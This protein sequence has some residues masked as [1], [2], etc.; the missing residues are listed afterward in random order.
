MNP[1][2][3]QEINLLREL[4]GRQ[5]DLGIVIGSHQNLDTY[6]AG[7]SLYA[8]LKAAG[9]K[10]Q[11]ISK[12][13]PT[14]EV[15]NLVGIDKVRENFVSGNNSKLVISLPYIKGEVEKVL[16]T[17]FPNPQNPTNINFHLTA[18]EG[19]SITPFSL[20]DVKLI[21]EGG[22]PGAIIT[23][24]V[25]YIDELAGIADDPQIKI[26]NI[27]NFSG[28]SRFGDVVLVD[29]SFSSLSEVS[30]KI[31]KDLALPVDID[32]AQNVLDGVLFATRNFTKPNTSPLAFEAASTAMYN[33]AQRSDEKADTRVQEQRQNPRPQRFQER[34]DDQREASQ[35]KPRVS[36][37]D[38]PAMH[39]QGSRNQGDER[40]QRNQQRGQEERSR[41]PQNQSQTRQFQDR[42]QR[43]QQAFGQNPQDIEELMRRINEENA[44]RNI[45]KRQDQPR[46]ERNQSQNRSEDRRESFSNPRVQDAEVVE[47]QAQ[48]R[49][50]E[51]VKMPEENYSPP[52]PSEVPD[53]WL[54]PKVF[55]S[56][57]NNNN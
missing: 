45:G 16:F 23:I 25:S 18:A 30:A 39:M 28:N 52:E 49:I 6:A 27:D 17:E 15:S 48:N 21:W 41:R 8:S 42:S 24:G 4:L 35:Q 14:V 55:K 12:K 29:E 22:A 32:S 9:K 50:P 26:V 31:I 3:V 20:S 53:D 5:G 43:P 40:R 11:I 2:I 1:N 38:F 44:K 47:D 46:Q 56:S 10:V 51:D 33:G 7:L 13:S 57:K 54:M 36:D 37:T 34:Q 19:K